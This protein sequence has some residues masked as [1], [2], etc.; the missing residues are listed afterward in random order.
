MVQIGRSRY[1][2]VCTQKAVTSVI[3]GLGCVSGFSGWNEMSLSTE[4]EEHSWNTWKTLNQRLQ[5][6]HLLSSNSQWILYAHITIYIHLYNNISADILYNVYRLV[7]CCSIC[8]GDMLVLCSCTCP[9][10]GD[11]ESVL[12]VL[13]CSSVYFSGKFCYLFH[14]HPDD[15]QKTHVQ[16]AR[17][18][19][20]LTLDFVGRYIQIYRSR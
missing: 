6:G 10:A 2:H 16:T 19:F 17:H 18:L 7:G 13:L 1:F 14:L 9:W 4:I 5:P 8:S 20:Y 15:A 12:W 11:D 3:Q